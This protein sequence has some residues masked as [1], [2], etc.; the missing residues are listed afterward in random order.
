MPGI[1]SAIAKESQLSFKQEFKNLE[2]MKGQGRNEGT[3]ERL[4]AAEELKGREGE[5]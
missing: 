3:V 5:A 2:G 4:M 1:S